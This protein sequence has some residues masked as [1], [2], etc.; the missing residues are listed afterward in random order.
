VDHVTEM[1]SVFFSGRTTISCW[2]ASGVIFGVREAAVFSM[3][4]PLFIKVETVAALNWRGR[5]DSPRAEAWKEGVISRRTSWTWAVYLVVKC[6][7]PRERA[8][9]APRSAARR[10]AGQ[11]LATWMATRRMSKGRTDLTG[12][13]GAVGS[14]GGR[15]SG[16][17]AI[18][19]AA[20][21]LAVEADPAR[22]ARADGRC[23]GLSVTELGFKSLEAWRM[24]RGWEWRKGRERACDTRVGPQLRGWGLVGIA[25]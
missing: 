1:R 16:D 11:P 10:M 22:W 24:R 13:V 21:A 8:A 3:S 20:A 5:K 23:Y 15:G 4:G 12:C 14:A 19:G 25:V 7:L 2:K 18:T 6:Q 9:A 17:G